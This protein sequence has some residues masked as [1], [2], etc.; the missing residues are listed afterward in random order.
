MKLIMLNYMKVLRAK[1]S[2]LVLP[3]GIGNDE[4]QLKLV[5][6]Q[7]AN[8]YPVLPVPLPSENWTKCDWEHLFTMYIG[9][10]YCRLF[11]H[12]LQAKLL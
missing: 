6:G 10:H 2:H 8:G 12:I 5:L 7:T 11:L 4:G 1:Q 3:F 9:W